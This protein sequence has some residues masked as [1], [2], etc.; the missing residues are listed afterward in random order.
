M[1][2]L[3]SHTKCQ[4][5]WKKFHL[6]FLQCAQECW[7]HV[8]TTTI[9]QASKKTSVNSSKN[10]DKK[11]KKEKQ[12]YSNCKAL[13]FTR[14]C[15]QQRHAMVSLGVPAP[16]LNSIS[17]LGKIFLCLPVN[18]GT[19]LNFNFFQS[20]PLCLFTISPLGRPEP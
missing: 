14:K 16:F 6:I 10:T 4:I 18:L 19:P 3:L 17:P 9:L 13:C 8:P 11:Q 2:S 5:N 7:L 12:Q 20:L 15:N 1:T